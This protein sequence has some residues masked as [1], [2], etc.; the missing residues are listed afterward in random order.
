MKSETPSAT[1]LLYAC[2]EL[3][4]FVDQWDRLRPLS[5]LKSLQ[6]KSASLAPNSSSKSLA[7][8][9]K[10]KFA[11]PGDDVAPNKCTVILFFFWFLGEVAN[12]PPEE[13]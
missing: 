6:R 13:L 12:F 5:T 8:D 11:Q 10:A 2:D 7:V 1:H 4:F 3:H 9:F